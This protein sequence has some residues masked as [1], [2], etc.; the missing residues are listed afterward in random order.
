MTRETEEGKLPLL[1]GTDSGDGTAS[2]QP[3]ASSQRKA[4]TWHDALRTVLLLMLSSL[5]FAGSQQAIIAAPGFKPLC[6]GLLTCA[7]VV[8]YTTFALLELNGSAL[9]ADLQGRVVRKVPIR[10]YVV[11]AILTYVSAATGN[12]ALSYVD[13]STRLLFKCAKP[14]PTMF[15]SVVLLKRRYRAMEY[16]AVMLLCSSVFVLSIGGKKQDWSSEDPGIDPTGVFLLLVAIV[17]DSCIGTYEQWKIFS[18]YEVHPSEV[19]LYSYTLSS[20]GGII[21]FLLSGEV[22]YAVNFFSDSPSVMALMALSEG[23][24]YLS[25]RLVLHLIQTFGATEA[26]VAKTLRK[27]VVYLASYVLYEHK[28]LTRTHALGAVLLGLSTLVKTQAK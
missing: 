22:S 9:D 27:C 26:E 14:L 2:E 28:P 18:Q 15:L 8:A 12:A 11:V 4:G 7:H 5:V 3:A 16:G 1:V 25:L 21:T 20:L 23:F 17:T 10:H 13:Y 19:L 6:H 24:G